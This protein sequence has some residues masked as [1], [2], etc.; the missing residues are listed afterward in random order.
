M[1]GEEGRVHRTLQAL[2]YLVS[3]AELGHD[4][5]GSM[6]TFDAKVGSEKPGLTMLHQAA[7]LGHTKAVK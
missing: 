7:A 3:L 6:A 4:I 2:D 5:S 1:A